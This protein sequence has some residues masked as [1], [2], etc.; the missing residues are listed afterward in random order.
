MLDPRAVFESRYQNRSGV[1]RRGFASPFKSAPAQNALP[2]PVTTPTRKTGSLSSH[3]HTASSSAWPA[4]LMQLRARGRE[5]VTSRMC[6]PG[7]ESLVKEVGG[8]GCVNGGEL[9]VWMARLGVY[10]IE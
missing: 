1:M 5:S 4:E 7:K 6:G 8:G 2:S 9:I 3:D 10:G